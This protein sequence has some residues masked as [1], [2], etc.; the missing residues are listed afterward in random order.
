MKKPTRSYLGNFVT[1]IGNYEQAEN[2]ILCDNRV[3]DFFIK[4]QVT[5]IWI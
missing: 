2:L 3:I 5:M 1:K 4:R